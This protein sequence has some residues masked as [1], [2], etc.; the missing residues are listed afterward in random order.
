MRRGKES[1]LEW[2]SGVVD[3]VCSGQLCVESCGPPIV[4]HVPSANSVPPRPSTSFSSPD[5]WVD[6]KLLSVRSPCISCRWSSS[7]SFVLRPRWLVL[8]NRCI[9]LI[10]CWLRRSTLAGEI[11]MVLR[12]HVRHRSFPSDASRRRSLS[13]LGA[14]VGRRYSTRAF[15]HGTTH[16]V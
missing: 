9:V 6:P 14:V 4:L 5:G 7:W 11:C 1:V 15:I 2:S 8:S 13:K 16:M 12:S 3:S 10:P